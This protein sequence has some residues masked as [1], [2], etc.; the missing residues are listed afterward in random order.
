MN[1]KDLAEHYMSKIV[2]SDYFQVGEPVND[3]NLLYSPFR[4]TI[5][6][7]LEEY[8][9]V[10][11]DNDLPYIFETFRSH[12]QQWNYWYAGRSKVRGGNILTAGMHHFGIAV[13]IVNLIDKNGNRTK[14]RGEMVDWENIDY[15]A[16]RRVMTAYKAFNLGSYE[17]CHFQMIPMA[18]QSTLRHGM[19]DA[20][21]EWQEKYDLVADG[22]VGLKTIAKAKE[23]FL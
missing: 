23:V 12:R 6:A 20:I 11:G 3:L 8:E 10:N 21:K 2:T 22:I 5:E 15:I 7:A 4:N 17:M 13:D 1:Y 18:E 16:M 19:Y 14:D 9:E